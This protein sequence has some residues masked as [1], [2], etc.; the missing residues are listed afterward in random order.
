MMNIVSGIRQYANSDRLAVVCDDEKLSYKDLDRYSDIIGN[1]ISQ[2]YGENTPV[3]IY[4]NKDV[5]IIACMIGALK[6]KRVYVPMDV[7]FPEQRVLDV[8]DSVRPNIVFDMSGKN[9]FRDQDGQVKEAYKSFEIIDK[10]NL[11]NLIEEN[12][13]GPL[14]SQVPSENWVDGDENSYILFTSGST[15]K[16][17]GVQI[18]AYNLDSFMRWMSPI[19]GL[20][21]QAKVVMDQ[22]AYSF[23]LSV[24]QLYPGLANGATL[25]SLSKDVVADF[26]VLFDHMRKSDMEVWVSTPSFV[27]MCLVDKDFNQEMLPKLRKMLYIGEVLPVEVARKLRERFPK[28]DIINGY[29]PTE[30]TVGI[31]H[32]IINDDH[33][34]SGKSLPVGLPMENC[35]IKIV[36]EEG[37]EVE[38]GQ[39]GEIVIIGPS[40]SKGYFKNE[41][42]TKEVF[43]LESTDPGLESGSPKDLAH[44]RFRAYKTGDLGFIDETGNIRYAG[45]KDFQI[46]LNGY[47]IEI[48]DIENNLRKV[49]NI[50]NAVVLPV[51]K[52]EKIAYLK[53]IVELE[54]E[55]DLGNL[56]NGIRIKKD[57]A[58]LVPEYMVP[59]NVTIIDKLP[60]NTNGKIDRKKL[61]Q[62]L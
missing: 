1:Y 37:R 21:G 23:D 33:I 6:S 22:P 39:K 15:G 61:A 11:I 54:V 56:K 51:Y 10:K 8:L 14:A 44:L 17:K 3:A 42:K 38:E 31:S 7:S 45:R 59:R 55:N 49:E 62:E 34:G 50:R 48:E 52:N 9:F 19:L 32:V 2:K 27:G 13:V 28:V 4:G 16:P 18:S 26:K 43:Y 58:K 35:K 40:V 36:D 46:K 20:D 29:G 57:L 12:K 30:A 53:A 60:M 24:S 5:M 41:E 47:R 25:Y